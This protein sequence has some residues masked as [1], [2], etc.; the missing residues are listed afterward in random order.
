M[1]SVESGG[2]RVLFEVPPPLAAR[3]RRRFWSALVIGLTVV[4]APL[5]PPL[6]FSVAANPLALLLV[7]VILAPLWSF[8]ALRAFMAQRLLRHSNGLAVAEE[9][10]YPPFRLP[11]TPRGRRSF[12]LLEEVDG[13]SVEEQGSDFTAAVTLLSGKGVVMTSTDL[14]RLYGRK[15]EEE[16]PK[17]LDA[18]YQLQAK[19][20]AYGGPFK[21]H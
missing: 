6:L 13:V 14:L 3:A 7:Y 9:G 15:M 11:G 19:V 4:A 20:A 17:L 8:G 5:T 16:F 12:I 18:L 10:V 2:R 1:G 21:G